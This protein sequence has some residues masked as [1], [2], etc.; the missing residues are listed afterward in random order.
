MA[1]GGQRHAGDDHGR[2]IVPAHGINRQGKWLRHGGFRHVW[3]WDEAA[4]GRLG[5]NRAF[6]RFAGTHDL[7]AVV[8]TAMAADV[9]RTLQ[10]P[11]IA[12]LGEG[13][14]LDGVVATTH[15]PAGRRRLSL[16]NGH[17]RNPF[18]VN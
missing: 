9:V 17:R 13:L 16:G 2:G 3:R 8:V 5:P 4:G 1:L 6:E 12:A 18:R 11:A 14:A 15:S 10:L 7:T